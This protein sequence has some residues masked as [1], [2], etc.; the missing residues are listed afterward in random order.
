MVIVGAG[1][2]GTQAA[3]SLRTS[4]F[5]GQIVLVGDEPHTP[6][7]RPPLSKEFISGTKG[8]EGLALRPIRFYAEKE[9]SLL[10]GVRAK[11]VRCVERRVELVDGSELDYD[12]LVVA[13][14]VR[15][16]ALATGGEPAEDASLLR[17]LDDALEL[18]A[19]L[20]GR[21]P[22][23]VVIVGGG[24]IGLEL[25][26]TAVRHDHR[27]SV[28]EAED[29]TM[30]RVASSEIADYLEGQHR[31]HG[32][33]LLLG[34]RVDSF[35]S[36]PGD[37]G[38]GVRLVDGTRLPASVVVAGIGVL[39]NE[40]WLRG[41][42]LK[43]SN[44]VVVDE[45]LSA[46]DP[47][48]SA[49]GDCARFPSTTEEGGSIRLESVQNAVDQA[50]YL[51]RRLLGETAAPYDTP[52][53]FWTHQ[54]DVR[55]Q[56]AGLPGHGSIR[57]TVGSVEEGRFS[58]LHFADEGR[59][60]CVESVNSAAEHMAARKMLSEKLH[61]SESMLNEFDGSVALYMKSRRDVGATGRQVGVER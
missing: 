37:V 55:V 40:D 51:A 24:F 8:A 23:D 7:Q 30:S 43:L 27:V 39:V 34:A 60:V 47:H 56:T 25:A 9:I 54:Y 20:V 44:G 10:T 32:V 35:R 4:G 3:I 31:A 48:V 1:Q 15:A 19:A 2:A 53:W 21:P 26:A 16:R 61:V 41:S 13:T 5:E 46:S 22:T 14:G 49:I 33:K 12:H 45:Y 6:Y 28:L 29:R 11:G 17:T 18:R 42:G 38:D 58:V 50:K 52:P 36:E 59:L 57:R